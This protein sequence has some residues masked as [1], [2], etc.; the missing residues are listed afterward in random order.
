MFK[1]GKLKKILLIIVITLVA[2]VAVVI[3]FISP[4]AKYAVEKYDVKLLG[5]EIEMNWVYVN[6]F[7]GYVHIKNLKIYENK[8]D[9]VFFSSEGV[10]ANFE[11]MKMLNKTYEFSNISLNKPVGRIIQNKKHLNFSD[12]IEKFTPKT[13]RD[14]TKE[15]LHFNILNIEITDGE[16]HYVE[17]TIPVNYF[18]KE[19]NIES[20]G[21]RWDVD[22]I[23]FNF[24]FLSGPATGAIKGNGAINLSNLDYRM[25][26]VANKFDLGI[27]QQYL[28]DLSNYGHFSANI[29]MDIKATGN[30]KD[31][32]NI[33]A[34]GLVAVN[35]FHFGEA[36]GDDFA[37][38]NKLV[39]DI[40]KL[41]PKEFEY[42]FDS[43]TLSKPFFKYERYDY[44]DN[45]SR[46][47]GKKGANIKTAVAERDTKFNLIIEI[48][49]YV[50][51]LAKNFFR[52]NYQIGKVA[53]YN[54]DFHFRDFSL[55]EKFAVAVYPFNIH[56][57]S[58]NKKNE[59]VEVFLETG[60]RPYGSLKVS[61]S[62]NPKDTA[63]FDLNY[64]LKKVSLAMLNPYVI[65]FT[66]Y[67]FDRGTLEFN[68]NWKVRNGQIESSNHLLLIDPHLTK[69]LKKKDAMALPLPLILAFIRENGN[70]IDY[71]IPIKGDLK[72]PKF[73]VWDAV[74]DLIG[75]IF[76]KPVSLPYMAHVDQVENEL[77]KSQ[78]LNWATHQS[79]FSPAQEKFLEKMKTFLKKDLT[80]SISVTPVQ[81]LEKEK[82]YILFYE[83]KKKYYL[84]TTIVNAQSFTED[85]SIKVEKMSVKDSLFVQYLENHANDSMLFTIQEKC[86]AYIDS[87][88][89]FNKFKSLSKARELSFRS[90]FKENEI[91][92][93]IK[94]LKAENTVP[95]NGFSFYKID[96]KG[97]IS[98]SLIKAYSDINELN[99]QPPREKY[100]EKRRAKK[101]LN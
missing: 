68:G 17:Q 70:V 77:E 28:K 7:T 88:V 36:E 79:S 92:S 11:M 37:S 19:V 63:E 35:D 29:D 44:L 87:A 15:S 26:V 85:D 74:F 46:M 99:Q 78:K 96:Y 65:T 10:S 93:R 42:I 82:E 32:E 27:V 14:T 25:A 59:R 71:Q 56:A 20:T 69:R 95:Y 101:G 91:E 31:Q 43:V 97:D 18:I 38:F 41:D 34:S 89:V 76:I 81:F 13:K 22:S 40:K 55:N 1:T 9:S 64:H 57:D 21:K 51:V 5:R 30:I 48:A 6:P 8:S 73:N 60:I 98:E 61:L 24:S 2:F 58:V 3:I 39:L 67:P 23:G 53:I 54:G 100:K 83:A 52:S 50:K 75:N 4:I 90:Y 84:S 49:D 86:M 16:F 33:S 94:F 62:I 47:F 80:A 72:N 45:L 66:S 12:L